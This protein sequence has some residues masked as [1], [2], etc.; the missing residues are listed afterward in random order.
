MFRR[1]PASEDVALH[2]S[3]EGVQGMPSGAVEEDPRQESWWKA[4]DG[5]AQAGAIPVVQQISAELG[6]LPKVQV[7]FASIRLQTSTLPEIQKVIADLPHD[8]NHC[9]PQNNIDKVPYNLN[10]RG[11]VG[12]LN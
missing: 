1:L 4:W 12:P 5:F 10:D 9:K 2:A 6:I 3:S 7:Q 11:N 8:W